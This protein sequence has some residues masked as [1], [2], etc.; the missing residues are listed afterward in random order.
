MGNIALVGELGREALGRMDRSPTPIVLLYCA[1]YCI[2]R[3]SLE[4]AKPGSWQAVHHLIGTLNLQGILPD[5]K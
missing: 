3:A 1:F 4:N 2:T 5:M